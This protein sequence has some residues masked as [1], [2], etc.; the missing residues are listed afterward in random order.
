AVRAVVGVQ[1]DSAFLAAGELVKPV[2]FLKIA[3]DDLDVLRLARRRVGHA[4]VADHALD[5]LDGA[6]KKLGPVFAAVEPVVVAAQELEGVG[7]AAV[8]GFDQAVGQPGAG[9]GAALRVE[10]GVFGVG[11][12]VAVGLAALGDAVDDLIEA[13]AQLG[14]AG[15]A[16]GVACAHEKAAGVGTGEIGLPEL[17]GLAE[18]GGVGFAGAIAK[19]F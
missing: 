19:L 15:P 10:N 7:A 17:V 18:A 1:P 5:A 12:D 11:H 3:L 8:A 13:F 4:R 9:V 14:V 6:T 16:Y 2:V